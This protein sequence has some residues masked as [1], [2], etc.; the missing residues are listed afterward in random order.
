MNTTNTIQ[1]TLILLL[2]LYSVVVFLAGIPGRPWLAFAAIVLCAVAVLVGFTLW[3][4]VYNAGWGDGGGHDYVSESIPIV[5]A[6]HFCVLAFSSL[7]RSR[8][9]AAALISLSAFCALGLFIA[10]TQGK[11]TGWIVSCLTFLLSAPIAWRVIRAKPRKDSGTQVEASQETSS[12]E[13]NW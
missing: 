2:L 10:A 8:Q 7:I 5:A 12:P 11:M 6:G 9:A 1:S 13:S 4:V 3:V